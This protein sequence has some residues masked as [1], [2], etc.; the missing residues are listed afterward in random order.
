MEAL[1]VSAHGNLVTPL[2]PAA[3]VVAGKQFQKRAR[4]AALD[5]FVNLP[6]LPRMVLVRLGFS[7]RQNSG[8]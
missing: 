7:F 3:P 2:R 4:T 1:D 8:K 6:W 5:D